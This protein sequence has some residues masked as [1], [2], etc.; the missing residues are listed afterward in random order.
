MT[1]LAQAVQT[2]SN[3]QVTNTRGRRSP[4]LE[5][6]R[7]HRDR[8]ATH[9]RVAAPR[10]SPRPAAARRRL[11]IFACARATHRVA[12]SLSLGAR[13]GGGWRWATAARE[14]WR[15]RRRRVNGGG[16][17]GGGIYTMAGDAGRQRDEFV[18]VAMGRGSFYCFVIQSSYGLTMFKW[19]LILIKLYFIRRGSSYMSFEQVCSNY[20]CS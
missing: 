13:H 4:P 1:T 7:P 8:V 18:L 15:R 19:Y 9:A 12:L 10:L 11:V 6:A 16:G 3:R 5:T 20:S 14:R 2:H 17:G